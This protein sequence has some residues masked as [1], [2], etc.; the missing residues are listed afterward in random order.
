M[1]AITNRQCIDLHDM[2]VHIQVNRPA[3]DY[4]EPIKS[5]IQSF[6]KLVKHYE[7]PIKDTKRMTYNYAF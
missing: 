4:K 6:K 2:L 5:L 3:G 1:F 7:K